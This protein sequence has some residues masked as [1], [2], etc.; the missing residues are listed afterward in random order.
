MGRWEIPKMRIVLGMGVECN[1]RGI[2]SSRWWPDLH[3]LKIIQLVAVRPGG[4]CAISPA[5]SLLEA[6]SSTREGAGARSEVAFMDVVNHCLLL[7]HN[8]IYLPSHYKPGG[9]HSCVQSFTSLLLWGRLKNEDL[10]KGRGSPLQYAS[11]TVLPTR[12]RLW[13]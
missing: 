11:C 13:L 12:S 3:S 8:A 4:K 5:Q 2:G 7:S 6:Q 9:P 10:G 1:R